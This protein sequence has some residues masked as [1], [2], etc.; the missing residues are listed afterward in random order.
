M[1]Q[2]TNSSPVLDQLGVKNNHAFPI[3]MTVSILENYKK[4]IDVLKK[5]FG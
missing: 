4:Q 5:I 3:N 2:D 1:V